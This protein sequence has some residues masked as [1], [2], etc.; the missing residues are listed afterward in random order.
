MCNLYIEP[1]ALDAFGIDDL[2]PPPAGKGRSLGPLGQGVVIRDQ[3]IIR[4]GRV[5]RAQWGLI[6]WFSATRTPTRNDG[7]RLSTNNCRVET[8]QTSPT[9]KAPWKRDQR[10]LIPADS[11]DEPYWGPDP[12]APFKKC[13]WWRFWRADGKPWAL[14]G[15][16]SEWH[17]KLRDEPVLSYTMLTQN[18]D[19]HAL[20][21]LMH[22]PDG[23]IP[24]DKRAVVPIERDD[25][26]TWLNGSK[27]EALALIR[28]P[29]AALYRHGPADPSVAVRLRDP[30]ASI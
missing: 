9:F 14:A 23:A 21:G 1:A 19:G 15:L 24:P 17:D 12:Q 28:V 4:P 13:V 26:D 27:E 5:D 3:V 20:L 18:C 2:P 25:W 29:P 22:K 8:M 6:P 11:Y 16:W 30:P 10:C 7:K